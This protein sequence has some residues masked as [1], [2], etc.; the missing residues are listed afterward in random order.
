MLR[1]S[2]HLTLDEVTRTSTGLVNVPTHEA[3]HELVH[4]ARS[5][6]E[7]WRMLVGPLRVTSGYRSA[8]VNAAVGGAAQSQHKRGQALD[9][10]P[11]RM[12]S[13]AAFRELARVVGK[14]PVD[15]AILYAPERGGHVHISHRSDGKN[16]GQLLYAPASGG[17]EP[18]EAE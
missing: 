16:R 14:I 11:L 10:K 4:L 9:L 7:P 3:L 2:P 15:Q 17:Y 12:S 6:F 1:L 13:A 18:W 8:A 5:V